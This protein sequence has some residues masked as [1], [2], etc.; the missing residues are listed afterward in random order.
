M[1]AICFEV[2]AVIF[3]TGAV[4]RYKDELWCSPWDRTQILTSRSLP[5]KYALFKEKEDAI[6]LKPKRKLAPI[7]S[8]LAL[9]S[10][11]FRTL[12]PNFAQMDKLWQFCL[13][14]LLRFYIKYGF[15]SSNFH[16]NPYREKTFIVISSTKF[17]LQRTKSVENSLKFQWCF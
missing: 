13:H 9:N 6:T 1:N 17:C 12:T 7:F 16:E 11:M 14:I 15:H 8:K 3:D 2:W 5:L 4:A 10:I